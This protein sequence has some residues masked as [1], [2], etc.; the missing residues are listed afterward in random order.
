[1]QKVIKHYKQTAKESPYIQDLGRDSIY[2]RGSH[3][4]KKTSNKNPL[5]IS[6]EEANFN[7]FKHKYCYCH[8]CYTLYVCVSI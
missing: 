1:M 3:D 6:D 8:L 2:N 5:S 4:I 7:L